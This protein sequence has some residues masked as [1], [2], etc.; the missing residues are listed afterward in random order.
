MKL[1]ALLEKF[2]YFFLLCGLQCLV[3]LLETD[4]EMRALWADRRGCVCR[5]SQVPPLPRIMGKLVAPPPQ[6]W[7][8]EIKIKAP[9]TCFFIRP[10]LPCPGLPRPSRQAS[11]FSSAAGLQAGRP[12]PKTTHSS[13]PSPR[14]LPQV[15]ALA[16]HCLP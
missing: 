9:S 3:N 4:V 14:L 1:N 6:T 11:S 16:C 8:Y 7:G 10:S 2:L 13:R 15:C 12:T 5:V